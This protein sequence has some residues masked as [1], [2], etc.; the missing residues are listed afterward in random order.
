MTLGQA[1]ALAQRKP[2]TGPGRKLFLACGFQPLHLATFLKA[3][4]AERFPDSYGEIETGL[5][6][7]LIGSLNRAAASEAEA[8]AVAVEWSD[9]DPRLG[10]RSTGGWAL[11]LQDEIVAGSE[12][13]FA[14]LAAAIRD[15]AAKKPIALAPPAL[16][17]RLLGHTAG[18][19]SSRHELALQRQLAAFLADAAAIRGVSV[20]NTASLARVSPEPSRQDPLLDLQ[21]GFP[22]TIAHTSALAKQFIQI[23]FPPAAGKGFITDLDDT[24]W[25]GIVGEVG[26]QGVTW[27][28][29]DH[30][31]VHGLYQQMLRHLSEMGVLL[32]IAS[33]NEAAVVEEALR[34]EDLL[35]SGQSFFPVCAHWGPKS[36]SIAEILR[37]WN[38]GPDSVV[39]ID[40]SALE[41]EEVRAAF[42]SMTCL[43]FPKKQPAKVVDLLEQLRDFFGKPEIHQEDALR[44]ASIRANAAFE[45]A[46]A[47]VVDGDFVRSLQGR[48]TFDCRKDPENHRLLELVNKT[49]QFNL[50]GT[51]LSE[52]EWRKQL[53]DD[54]SLV[55]GVSHD[56]KF[57]PLGTIAV[58][59]GRKVDRDIQLTSWVLSC[60]AFSRKIEHHMM[61]FL[62]RHCQAERVRMDY[63]RT[64]RNQ[65]LQS[66]LKT[67]GLNAD[68][69]GEMLL[70]REQFLNHSEDLPH[71]VRYKTND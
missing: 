50:N 61:D 46:K 68:E 64:S 51:R 45:A 70:S 26:V 25:S 54:H 3:H 56:E 59:A 53:E 62:F 48:L 31:Q 24:F 33:K 38:I 52:G 7:D 39:F 29:A 9:I 8:I 13:Q 36:N 63:R 28:L 19:Q 30:A 66:Y 35:V 14:R 27:S 2:K 41:I 34:R 32:A 67:L 44:Q 4:F 37:A 6:G 5:Y 20:L 17:L 55:V 22:Y 23:L 1:L 43:Q 11:S 12:A 10:L 15:A 40:D 71:Q 57:G 18:W 58:I 60:R 16:P 65:P 47:G 49:N 69:D 42:P 21:A